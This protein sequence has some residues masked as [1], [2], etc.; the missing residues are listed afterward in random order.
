MKCPPINH[1]DNGRVY[2][3]ANGQT[4]LFICDKDYSTVGSPISYC[5]GRKWSFPTPE[6]KKSS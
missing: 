6:C 2:I 5:D 3:I 4:A 1:P